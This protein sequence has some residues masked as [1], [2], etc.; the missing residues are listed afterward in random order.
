[1]ICH[2][3]LPLFA[4]IH[5]VWDIT[6]DLENIFHFL[7]SKTFISSNFTFIMQLSTPNPPQNVSFSPLLFILLL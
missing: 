6:Q 4:F 2:L 1:M 3:E 5:G 7:S